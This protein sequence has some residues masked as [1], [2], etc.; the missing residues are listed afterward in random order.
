MPFLIVV[1]G[2]G[3][4]TVRIVR[5]HIA[6]IGQFMPESPTIS[7]MKYLRICTTKKGY[8]YDDYRQ[9]FHMLSS[10]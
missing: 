3:L 5:I 8:Q 10:F 7:L 1:H 4:Q 6:F 2:R 9:F